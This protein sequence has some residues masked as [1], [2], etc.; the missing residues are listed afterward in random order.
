MRAW[1]PII[2]LVVLV[3]WLGLITAIV[4]AQ[5]NSG[6]ATI[7]DDKR[8]L[9]SW[10]AVA[11]LLSGA[12]SI[13]TAMV[14]TRHHIAD[15]N[16]HQTGEKLAQTYETRESCLHRHDEIKRDFELVH[17]RLDEQSRTLGRIEGKLDTLGGK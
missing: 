7:I 5:A 15:E 17:S 6:P 1:L 10:G 12:L 3:V 14:T 13:A 2:K 16:R 9:F 8:L 11:I 4:Y